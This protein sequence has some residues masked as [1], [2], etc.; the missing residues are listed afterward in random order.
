V[1]NSPQALNNI[2]T[3]VERYIGRPGQA[4]AYM[5]GR[6][7][8]MKIRAEAE[9]AMGPRFDIKGFHDALLDSGPVPLGVL[10]K[11]VEDWA[12]A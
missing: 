12:A 10:R 5:I 7:E 4:L 11:L 1:H 2:E 6:R 3:E 9:A 8:I